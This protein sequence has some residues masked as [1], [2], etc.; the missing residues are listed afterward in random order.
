MR[1]RSQARIEFERK[2]A[3]TLSSVRNSANANNSSNT[4][5]LSLTD[6]IS[7]G[8]ECPICYEFPEPVDITRICGCNHKFCFTCIDRWGQNKNT[9]PLCNSVFTKV[10]R[11]PKTTVEDKTYSGNK[12]KRDDIQADD[13]IAAIE[14]RIEE[15]ELRQ[16]VIQRQIEAIIRQRDLL[17][18]EYEDIRFMLE[19]NRLRIEGMQMQMQ[20]TEYYLL[21]RIEIER[22]MARFRGE[23]VQLDNNIASTNSA[24]GEDQY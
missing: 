13:R 21:R 7:A 18:F 10:I 15:N 4:N 3:S 6:T 23:I 2:A 16:A 9:C 11:G 22:L 14:A 8:V 12:R 24:T 17:H 19:L 5:A 1:T 20:S